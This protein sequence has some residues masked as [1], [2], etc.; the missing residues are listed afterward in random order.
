MNKEGYTKDEIIRKLELEISDLKDMVK[1]HK[2]ES[3]KWLKALIQKDS[4][5][6]DLKK[7]GNTQK[8]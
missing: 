4:E 6:Y 5:L 1:F 8:I 3:K 2:L 7:G